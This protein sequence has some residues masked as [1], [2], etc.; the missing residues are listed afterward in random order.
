MPQR[1]IAIPPSRAT[2]CDILRYDRYV[3][4]FAHDRICNVAP[5]LNARR[6]C[7]DRISW[8]AIF[9]K[10]YA[11]MANDF[12]RLQQTWMN[13]PLPHLYQHSEHVGTLVVRREFEDDEWLFWA[14]LRDLDSR[15]LS[16]IQADIDRFQNESVETIYRRQLWM[17]RLPAIARRICWWLTFQVSGNKKCKRLGTFFL[18]TISGR[19]AEIQNPPS[20]LTSGFTYGPLSEAGDTRVTIT[21]D[22]RLLDGHHVADMLAK[23]ES[24]LNTQLL[25]ELQGQSRA[26]A[27]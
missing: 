7:A 4:S 27:A 1:R 5:L 21:Y 18:T 23:L 14:Q 10:A 13:W 22:H 26:T 16:E 25:A 3:P 11:I 24:V 2:V 12:P 9:M 19:G 20:M 17:A 15:S 6:S 8:P